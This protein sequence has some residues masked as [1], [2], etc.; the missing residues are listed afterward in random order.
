MPEWNEG[1]VRAN[2]ARIHYYRTGGDGPR[3]LA[4][5]GFTD[6]GLCWARVVRA[7]A[8]DYDVIIPDLRGHGLSERIEPG[9]P[10]DPAADVIGLIDRLGLD[11]PG[12][13][14][15]SLGAAIAALTAARWP[16]RVG[17]L[18]LEDPPWRRASPPEGEQAYL[19]ERRQHLD[20]WQHNLSQLQA[21]PR[22]AVVAAGRGQHP[23]W[24]DAEVQAWADAKLQLDLDVFATGLLDMP[25]WQEI[26]TDIACPTLLITA[27]PERGA[28]VTPEVSRDVAR[29]L[30]QAEVVQIPDAGHSIRRDQYEATLQVITRFLR[31]HRDATC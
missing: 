19:G 7:L 3:L 25:S 27:D 22:D 21:Q 17:L 20:D 11:R 4:I 31:A 29:R 8:G 24:D 12:L 15:H 10:V 1:S 30:P 5:H 16:G 26:I 6:N 13:L 23:A 2:G 9:E 18:V 28:I 14:G